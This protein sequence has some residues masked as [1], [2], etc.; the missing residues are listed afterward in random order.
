MRV[1]QLQGA[2][3]AVATRGDARLE[4]HSSRT[5]LDDREG[6]HVAVRID[7]DHVVEPICKHPTHLQPT[8]GGTRSGGRSGVKT[9]GG[10]TVMS[11]AGKR[12]TG[13]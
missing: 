1:G 7:A 3:V 11:H 13:F 2:R 8:L 10:R 4:D 5:H 6:V 9:A 12:R